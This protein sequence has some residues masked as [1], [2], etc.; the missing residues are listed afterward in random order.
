[1]IKKIIE[2]TEQLKEIEKLK[3]SQISENQNELQSQLEI[4]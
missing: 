2:N 3:Q 4:S 1:M